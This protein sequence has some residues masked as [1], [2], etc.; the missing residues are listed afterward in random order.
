MSS[1]EEEICN[2][3]DDM[4]FEVEKTLGDCH[5][6]LIEI[7]TKMTYKQIYSGLKSAIPLCS[8]EKYRIACHNEILKRINTQQS[9][10]IFNKTKYDEKELRIENERLLKENETIGELVKS[11]LTVFESLREEK[12]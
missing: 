1:F 7:S 11:N 6:R 10:E 12:K 4:H 5:T 8:S 3:L 9:N 2:I